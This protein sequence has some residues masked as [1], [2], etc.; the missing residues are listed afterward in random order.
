MKKLSLEAKLEIIDRAFGIIKIKKGEKFSPVAY[1]RQI[2]KGWAK[3][4]KRQ[5]L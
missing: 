4:L 5:G 2:R 3:R 1:Q